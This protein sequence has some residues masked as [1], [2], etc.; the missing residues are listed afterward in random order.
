SLPLPNGRGDAS[1]AW[2]GQ[3]F[4]R[5]VAAEADYHPWRLAGWE[6]RD[7]GIGEATG[8]LAGARVAR[9]MAGTSDAV[10]LDS[11]FSMLV[12]LAGEVTFESGDV[13]ERLRPGSS[14]AV[15]GGRAYR[16]LDATPDCELLDVTLPAE[17]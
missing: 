14:V 12:G 3:R 11:E 1:R 10:A 16:L 4:V 13:A 2:D 7:T 17:P 9:A 5:H 6:Y 15:P 8:G